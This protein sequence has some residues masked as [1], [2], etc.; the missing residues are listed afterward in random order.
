[1]ALHRAFDGSEPIRP[2]PVSDLAGA[3]ELRKREGS[4][5]MATATFACPRCDAPV[6]PGPRSLAPA[7]A[8]RCPY[9]AHAGVVR[10]FLTLGDPARPAVVEVRVTAEPLP[11]RAARGAAS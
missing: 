2:Q 9:C 4:Q 10:D 1:M 11:P 6:S 8:A 3:R 7:E 5:V